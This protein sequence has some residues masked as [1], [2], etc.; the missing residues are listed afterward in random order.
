[1]RWLALLA[2]SLLASCAAPCE[3]RQEVEDDPVARVT[4]ADF[5]PLGALDPPPISKAEALALVERSATAEEA[6]QHLEVRPFSFRIDRATIDAFAERGAEQ[7][8]LDY[9]L[10]RGHVEWRD[11][12]LERESNDPVLRAL[13]KPDASVS[14]RT[15]YG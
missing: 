2:I 12:H 11:R 7:E 3:P 10:T 14:P 1:M 9:L 5:F 4:S 13:A 15:E 6:I 8:V